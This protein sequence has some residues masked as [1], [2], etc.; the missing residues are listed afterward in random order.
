MSQRNGLKTCEYRAVQCSWSTT[1]PC[2][3]LHIQRL[4]AKHQHTSSSTPVPTTNDEKPNHKFPTKFALGLVLDANHP[5][6]L[7]AFVTFSQM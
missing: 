2:L 3:R 4:Y 7:P 6:G 5:N 1:R